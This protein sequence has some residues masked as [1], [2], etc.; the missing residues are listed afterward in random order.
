VLLLASCRLYG[1]EALAYMRDLFCLSPNSPKKRVLQLAP[2]N[3]K[4][5]LEQTDT[6]VNCSPYAVSFPRPV[7]GS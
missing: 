7:A 4:Q 3:W 2:V 1:I 6:G 5:T